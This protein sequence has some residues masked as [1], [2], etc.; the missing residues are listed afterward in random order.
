MAAADA[1]GTALVLVHLQKAVVGPGS[2]YHEQARS[3][4]VVGQASRLVRSASAGGIPVVLTRLTFET[5]Q[6]PVRENT[7]LLDRVRAERM[8]L[9]GDEGADIVTELRLL[10]D[11]Q[12]VTQQRISGFVDSSLDLVLRARDVSRILLAG[13][14]TD[15]SVEG[16]AR[17]AVDLGYRV[18]VIEDACASATPARHASS[19]ATLGLLATVTSTARALAWMSEPH[20]HPHPADWD[21]ERTPA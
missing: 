21:D 16:T 1:S 3:R 9:D 8:C 14:A 17:S 6:R 7:P 19:M 13:V 20:A 11:E 15:I 18:A 12:I 5:T 10:G 4:D 2:R